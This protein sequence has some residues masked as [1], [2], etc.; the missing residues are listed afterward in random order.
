MAEAAPFVVLAIETACLVRLACA[1]IAPFWLLASEQTML[2][3]AQVWARAVAMF[4][5]LA[6]DVANLLTIA[7]AVTIPEAGTSSPR[8]WMVFGLHLSYR[9]EV[10]FSGLTETIPSLSADER[11]ERSAPRALL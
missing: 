7:V 1:A 5:R 8:A 6:R 2:A 11:E 3:L 4:V 10:P 9:L